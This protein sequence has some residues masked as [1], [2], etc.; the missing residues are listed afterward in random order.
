[1]EPSKIIYLSSVIE[2]LL[3]LN[4]TKIFL[5]GSQVK[6]TATEQS[7]FDICIVLEKKTREI[8]KL[9]LPENIELHVFD[10]K[11]FDELKKA[12]DPLIRDILRDG[13][14]IV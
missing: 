2:K 9:K 14:E 12:K 3:E 6:G 10:L 5:F 13:I 1:M 7:D 8:I 11:E 4:P